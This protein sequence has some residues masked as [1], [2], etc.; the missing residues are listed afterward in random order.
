MIDGV[1]TKHLKV[2]SDE[3][4]DLF[5]ILRADDEIYSKF[6]QAYL[7]TSYP[8]VIKA[9]HLHKIQTD[10][11]CV[12]RG[13]VKFVLYDAR[14]HSPTYGEINEF[15]PGDQN[16]MVIQIPPGVYHGFKNIG[17]EECHVLNI[18][19]EVYKH[20]NP[21]EF[22]LDPTDK[23]IPYYWARRDG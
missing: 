7:T 9:W 14:E 15:F 3:R 11:M 8:G 10:N 23:K 2:N 5:E 19:T 13:R 6:G 1:K 4:G 12:I 20:D 21:D 17:T 16:R 22:R 18:P